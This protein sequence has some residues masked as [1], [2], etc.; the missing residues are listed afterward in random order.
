MTQVP[1][2]MALMLHKRRKC[3][4][5]SPAWMGAANLEGMVFLYTV[6]LCQS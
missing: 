4:I 3:R 2:W 5:N 1:L 6:T